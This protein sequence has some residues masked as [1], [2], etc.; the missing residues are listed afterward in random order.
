MVIIVWP[1][2]ACGA[3]PSAA[4]QADTSITDDAEASPTSDVDAAAPDSTTPT[5]DVDESADAV[6]PVELCEGAEDGTPCASDSPCSKA[7]TC[8]AEVCEPDTPC[9]CSEDSDCAPPEDLC[10]GVMVC[11]TTGDAPVCVLDTD[12]AV[13]CEPSTIP[14]QLSQCEPTTGQCAS[15]AAPDGDTCDDADACTSDDVCTAGACLGAT[16]VVCDDGAFCNGLET[17]A[18]ETGCAPGEPPVLDDGVE[19]TVDSCDEDA[20]A[21]V[22]LAQDAACSNGF[23]CDG[24]EVCDASAGCLPGEAPIVDD[25]VSCTDDA[26]DEAA[27]A[28]VHVANDGLCNDAQYCNG[29]ES[30]DA[31]LDCQSGESP[32]LDDGVACT[33]DTC[34]EEADVVVHTAE[35]SLCSN[36]QFCDGAEVCDAALDCQPGL[37][38]V[39]DD[40]VGC[41][42]DS[43]DEELDQVVHAPNDALCDDALFCTGVETCD[44]ALDCQA[45]TPPELDDG[46]SCTVDTCD[47]EVDEVVHTPEPSLCD[48]DNPCTAELC[49]V[50]EGCGHEADDTGLCSDEDPCTSD[51]HCS[52]SV[53]VGVEIL[54]EGPVCN[55]VDDDCD[56]VT[57]EDCS[58]RLNGY[59]FGDG[60][61]LGTDT[62]GRAVK[63]TVGAPR[64]LGTSSNGSWTLKSGLPTAKEK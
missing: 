32:V 41:T 62:T 29:V 13:T 61:G 30:C 6:G 35:D 1:L 15:V 39:L 26:C 27:D 4:P 44:A 60:F 19:C 2:A 5:T 49:D 63:G 18:A 43:C 64:I 57:D 52:D 34:D 23:F 3:S 37:P 7:G 14:C 12:Q 51:D 21:V 11:D 8:Q 28:V 17:C 9:A 59:A 31:V 24:E 53:C 48:D 50:V 58:Y 10:G 20:D 22:H 47:D 56:G 36:G 16:P 45:G 40:E 55:S 33:V 42:D 38:P 54:S 46:V 25:G